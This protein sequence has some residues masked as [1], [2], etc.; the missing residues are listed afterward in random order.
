[1][2]LYQLQ[3]YWWII[4]SLLSGIFVFL[5]FVQGGQTFMKTLPQNEEEKK[6]LINSLGRKWELTFT[7]LV[8]FGG[9]MFAAFPLFYATSFSGAYWLWLLILFCF[10]IQAVSYEFRIKKGNFLGH[11]IYEGFLLING[12]FGSFL[13]GIVVAT[14]FNGSGFS[15]NQNNIVHWQ[16][17]MQG[18]ESIFNVFNLCL[19]ASVLWLTRLLGLMYF[20]NNIE[21][22]KILEKAFRKLKFNTVLFLL[23]FLAFIFQLYLL[24]G[25][26]T[27]SQFSIVF[28]EKNKYFHNLVQMPLIGF[29]F[30][31]GIVLVI[32][33]LAISIFKKYKNGIWF[34]GIGTILTVFALVAI[35][36]LNHTA[37]YPSNFD[38]QSSLT[39]ANSSSSKYTLAVMGYV[40]LII[41]IVLIYIWYVWKK[42]DSKSISGDEIKENSDTY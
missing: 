19:G 30:L 9:A 29:L 31:T 25:Y 10:I 20:I 23:F 1:M 14:F 4:I 24:K 26:E 6:I 41:P 11:K 33:G 16:S 15:L 13:I 21:N 35:T 17:S 18:L 27:D 8:M 5:M 2:S 38:L 22:E 36:G 28:L 37:F 39:I 7:T 32:S 40:T 42:M 12:C 34:S 3:Q